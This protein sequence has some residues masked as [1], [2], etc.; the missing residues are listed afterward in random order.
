MTARNRNNKESSEFCN[1]VV[2]PLLGLFFIG[3]SIWQIYR[4]E[5]RA[6]YRYD[7]LTVGMEQT[8][9]ISSPY[10]DLDPSNNGKLVHFSA[11]IH[12]QTKQYNASTVNN[13]SS[14]SN[15]INKITTNTI[16]NTTTSSVLMD[17]LFGFTCTVSDCIALKR[18]VEMYQWVESGKTK[19][20]NQKYSKKWAPGHQLASGKNK[21]LVRRFFSETFISKPVMAGTA[22][23]LPNNIVTWLISENQNQIDVTTQTQVLSVYQASKR[24]EAKIV[25]GKFYYSKNNEAKGRRPVLGDQRVW[26]TEKRPETITVVGVQ[27]ENGTIQEISYPRGDNFLFSNPRSGDIL[28]YE[29]GNLTLEEIYKVAKSD[30]TKITWGI[31][32]TMVLLLFLGLLLLLSSPFS[33]KLPYIKDQYG[34]NFYCL[35]ME[36]ALVL[37]GLTIAITW[38]IVRPITGLIIIGVFLAIIAFGAVVF[39]LIL[40]RMQ[41]QQRKDDSSDEN[42]NDN[43][44]SE[45]E[46]VSPAS[47][48]T[49]DA[50]NNLANPPIAVDVAHPVDDVVEAIALPPA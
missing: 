48:A 9:V 12:G 21:M 44:S 49:E 31:R 14:S 34:I 36:M 46:E 8:V 47:N 37:S 7:A 10:D 29:R 3:V 28:L 13:N 27:G 6:V 45:N 26:F 23:Q 4:N 5:H 40:R 1:K 32:A 16:N 24:E 20:G 35:S 22:F 41:Q 30:N 19:N 39:R 2:A 15:S 33:D 43:D 42:N 38:L 50:N 18:N 25:D 11:L 17:P